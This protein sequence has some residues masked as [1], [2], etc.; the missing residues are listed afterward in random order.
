MA[1][2][3]QRIWR[4]DPRRV[5]RTAWGYTLQD[6]GKQERKFNSAWTQEDAQRELAAR[7]LERDAP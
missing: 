7:I 2:V 1:D 4:S 6:D 5:R 3:T